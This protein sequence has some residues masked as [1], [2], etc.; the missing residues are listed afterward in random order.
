MSV[1]LSACL[2]F[3]T[4][5]HVLLSLSA[6][7]LV[8]VSV[9]MSTCLSVY[10]CKDYGCACCH[11]AC[12]LVCA[13]ACLPTD[14]PAFSAVHASTFFPLLWRPAPSTRFPAPALV[15]AAETY[16]AQDLSYNQIKSPAGGFNWAY[17]PTFLTSLALDGN[18]LTC[19]WVTWDLEG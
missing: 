5:T 3:C 9:C 11:V 19:V 14:V 16:A 6:S 2:H 17:L 10:C 1:C 8:C 15:A 18:L 12:H 7:L 4:P 13:S